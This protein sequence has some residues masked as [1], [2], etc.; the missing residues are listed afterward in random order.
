MVS[1]T[2]VAD[3]LSTVDGDE[4]TI[5]SLQVWLDGSLVLI[6]DFESSDVPLL[7]RPD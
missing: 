7:F 6:T 2:S 5:L 1:S 4:D 3:W